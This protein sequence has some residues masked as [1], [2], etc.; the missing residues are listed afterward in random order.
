MAQY[1]GGTAVVEEGKGEYVTS[2]KGYGGEDFYSLASLIL[3]FYLLWDTAG[4]LHLR[5]LYSTSRLEL[6]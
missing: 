3:Y 5:L 1:Q 6:V 4:W 2:V